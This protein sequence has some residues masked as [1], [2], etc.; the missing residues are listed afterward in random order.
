MT[1][2]LRFANQSQF[3]FALSLVHLLFLFHPSLALNLC[4]LDDSMMPML[5]VSS[6]PQWKHQML[7]LIARIVNLSLEV[8]PSFAQDNI[9][10]RD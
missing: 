4:L 6:V 5:Y 8:H 7:M 9:N 3:P 10:M 2:A 1:L